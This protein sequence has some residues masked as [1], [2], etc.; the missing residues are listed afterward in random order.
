MTQYR[1][2]W[3]PGSGLGLT[4][5]E[6]AAARAAAARRQ[7]P[8]IIDPYA[9]PLVSAVG[10][11]FFTRLAAGELDE[12]GFAL[13][14]MVDWVAT[15]SRFFDDFLTASQHA[16]TTQVV[17]IGAGL[18][19]RAYRLP[20]SPGATLYELDL[21]EVLSF[22]TRTMTNLG[23]H[24]RVDH[25]VVGVDLRDDWVTVLRHN[26]FDDTVPTA[27]SAEGLMPYLPATTRLRLLDGVAALSPAGSRFAADTVV[28][29]DKLRER[30]A[31]SPGTNVRPVEHRLD[32]S[33]AAAVSGR[34]M[35]AVHFQAHRWAATS[36]TAAA[37]FATYGVPTPTVDVIPAIEFVTAIRST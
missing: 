11:E 19:S 22:K 24:P 5:T 23:V 25:R 26:G 6:A 31:G 29:V 20:W 37:V 12:S 4:A 27:W 10:V 30:I 15:R 32:T 13:P 7:D 35:V 3:D 18:D 8:L 9:E 36:F 2:D 14:G 21:A 1:A 33:T 16:G 34:E 28:D 17:I